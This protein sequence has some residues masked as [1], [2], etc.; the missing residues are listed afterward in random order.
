MDI[1][2]KHTNP[3]WKRKFPLSVRSEIRWRTYASLFMG[4]I[5]GLAILVVLNAPRIP[6][7]AISPGRPLSVEA[8]ISVS[9]DSYATYREN[10]N[11]QISFVTVIITN[12]LTPI[13]WLDLTLQNDARIFHIKILGESRRDPT[14]RRQLGTLEIRNSQ[15]TAVLVAFEKLGIDIPMEF[16]GLRVQNAVNCAPASL[17]LQEN[18]II[19]QMDEQTVRQRGDLARILSSHAAGDV[20]NTVV[21][22]GAETL[23]LPIELIDRAGSCFVSFLQESAADASRSPVEGAA[24]G[25]NIA[26]I[27]ELQPPIDVNFDTRD[28]GGSSAGLAFTLGLIDLLEPGDLTGGLA[29]AAT[30]TISPDGTVGQVGAVEEKLKA[31]ERAN[32]DLFFVPSSQL[33]LVEGK[34]DTVE[35][36]G[37][38][39]LDEALAALE[40]RGGQPLTKP[41][42]ILGT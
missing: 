16:L 5:V 20:V 29:I 30:G 13:R 7:F 4:L 40:A 3:V 23:N 38:N 26:Q 41:P 39:N 21:E 15:Q 24:I 42:I 32:H 19:V 6:Y 17:Q 8:T 11:G 12:R 27:V 22:R 33:H 34:S 2:E 31:A 10:T 14:E 37:V 36:I 18:D 25:I 1:Q 35:I 9:G 28:I